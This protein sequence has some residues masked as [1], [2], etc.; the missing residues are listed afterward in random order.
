VAV[1]VRA[2]FIIAADGFCETSRHEGQS[3]RKH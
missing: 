1:L 3:M 2:S